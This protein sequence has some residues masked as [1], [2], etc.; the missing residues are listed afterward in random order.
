M[1]GKHYKLSILPLFEKDFNEIVDYISIHL[2]NPSAAEA[3]VDA[4]EVAI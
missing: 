1:D 2:Q 4:V 3:F